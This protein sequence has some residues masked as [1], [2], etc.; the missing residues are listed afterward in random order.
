MALLM[1]P[2]CGHL[3]HRPTFRFL[4]CRAD[5]GRGCGRSWIA[6]SEAELVAAL[7]TRADHETLCATGIFA[8]TT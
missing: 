7:A 5:E 1:A 4:R 8:E 6:N 3:R 2:R